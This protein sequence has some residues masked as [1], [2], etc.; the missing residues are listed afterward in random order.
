V[1]IP[2]PDPVQNERHPH[3]IPPSVVNEL[4]V[5]ER[6]RRRSAVRATPE[7]FHGPPRRAPLLGIPERR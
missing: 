6:E 2:S 1:L 7:A 3:I 5:M 4:K